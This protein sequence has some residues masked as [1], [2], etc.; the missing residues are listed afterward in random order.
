MFE[1]I[2]KFFTNKSA[3]TNIAPQQESQTALEDQQLKEA[4]VPKIKRIKRTIASKIEATCN[5]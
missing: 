2:K 5:K 4:K 3:Q 1:A